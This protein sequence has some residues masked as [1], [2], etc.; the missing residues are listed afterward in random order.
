[1]GRLSEIV[2]DVLRIVRCLITYVSSMYLILTGH[3]VIITII[4]IAVF[5]F[6]YKGTDF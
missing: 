1:M 6:W 5:L 4:G 3:Y 2:V